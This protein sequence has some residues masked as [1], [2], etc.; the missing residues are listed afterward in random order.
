MITKI[1]VEDS[2]D[3]L[4]LCRII[5]RIYGREDILVDTFGGIIN[6]TS[7]MRAFRMRANK[8]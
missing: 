7:T 6:I 4:E 8:S 3:G 1:L 2:A 5:N